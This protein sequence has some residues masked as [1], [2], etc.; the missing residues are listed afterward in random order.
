MASFHDAREY[1]GNQGD[2]EGIDVIS[3]EPIAMIMPPELQDSPKTTTPES[4]TSLSTSGGSDDHRPSTS[5]DSPT[6]ETPSE[7][8]GVEV[9]GC[10]APAMS[11]E[12]EV[13]VFEGWESKVISGRLDNLRKAPKTLPAG[14]KFRAALHHEVA[15]GAAIVKGYKKLEEMVRRYQIPKTILIRAGTPNEW[16]LGMLVKAVVFRSLFLCRL[17]PSTSKTRWYYISGRE[18]MMIFTNIRNKVARWKRQ[19]VFVCDTRTERINNELAAHLSEWRTPNAY[20]N[21]PQLT[22]GD[23]DLK[24]RLLDH[25]KARGLADLEALVTLE[26]IALLGFVDVANLHGEGEMSSILERQPQ[27]AQGSRNRGAGS[28]SQHQTRFDERPSATPGAAR[29]TKVRAQHQDHVLSRELKL[30]PRVQEGAHVRTLT[31]RMTFPSSGGGRV[32]D[33]SPPQPLQRSY[34]RAPDRQR[35][36]G[37]V[38]QHGGHAALLK[39]MDA[40]SYTVALFECEQGTR[41]QNCELQQNCKQLTSEKSSLADEVSRLQSSKMVNQAA[42]AE[43][44]ADGLAHIVNELR[45]ELEKAQAERESGIQAAKEK[46]DRAE[47]RAKKVES[48]REKT[49]HELNALKERVVDADLH[50]AEWLVGADM[51]QDVVAIASAKTT[52]N[53]FNEVHGK[54]LRHRADFPIGELAFFEG[55][56]IDDEGKSL[57]PPADTQDVPVEPSSTPPSSQLAQVTA[58]ALSPPDRSSPTRSAAA[59]TNAFIPV[60][61]TDD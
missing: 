49:L 28:G 4:S 41:V 31:Q 7:A 43:S 39:L 21:Y 40:F 1:R 44:R 15:D 42:S 24:N 50:G 58:P 36:K 11:A 8:E 6:E 3:M 33:H 48:N 9:V 53:I 19:F 22:V 10:N 61:L 37:H 52:T 30:H 56:D 55:E 16:R 23:V 20:M 57:A 60:D 38:Q 29:C 5:S 12:T 18:K 51:F 26:Q 17:C 14:F 25:V 27:R 46:A 13:V 47:D 35:V 2:E 54:V 59:P 34:Q 32:R 45:E